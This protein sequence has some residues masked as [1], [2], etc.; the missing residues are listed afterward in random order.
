MRSAIILLSSVALAACGMA[1][2]AQENGG[3]GSSARRDFSVG[4]FDAVALA[5][6]HDVIVTVGGA[7]AVRA[8][9]DAE[10][11]EK[12]DIEVE[13]G[14]LKI[15]TKRGTRW[16]SGFWNNRRP[17]TVYVTAPALNAAVVAGSGDMRIDAVQ[18][19][20]FKAT[21][22]GSGDLEIGTMRVGQANFSV[23]GSGDI[24]ASGS[25]N[26]TQAK[27]AG[28]GD[29]NLAG[30]ETRT[31]SVSIVGSGD[32][33]T[34]ATETVSVSIMGSGNVTVAGTAKCTVTK[35]GSG[36]VNCG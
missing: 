20:R 33:R 13:D 16:P 3:D 17:V 5:G 2:D 4:A 28:S 23:A 14:T 12:L 18:G 27:I 32:V 30:F 9:G 11:I 19:D 31:A 34:R 26:A 21:V 25:A 8:E 35:R 7:P 6:S 15:G 29:I 10:V 24:T 36:E 22:A 1:A